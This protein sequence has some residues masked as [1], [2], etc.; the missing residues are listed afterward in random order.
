ML[1]I[2]VPYVKSLYER[3]K[4]EYFNI[5]KCKTVCF[6]WEPHHDRSD[7]GRSHLL[8]PPERHGAR[9]GKIAACYVSDQPATGGTS[10][11]TPL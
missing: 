11:E 6:V 3:N 9:W 10:V 1:F 2:I 5:T 4:Y 7:A 8:G